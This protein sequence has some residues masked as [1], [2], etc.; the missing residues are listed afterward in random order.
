MIKAIVIDDEEKSRKV[1]IRLIEEVSE[2]INV[3]GEAGSVKEGFEVINKLKP[4][5]VFLDIEML[6]G[7]GFKLLEKFNKISFDVIFTTAYD[8]YAIR[9]FKFSALDYLLKPINVDDLESA[10]SRVKKNETS[11]NDKFALIE[12]LLQNVTMLSK[13]KRI[14]IKGATTIDYLNINEIMYCTSDLYLTEFFLANGNKISSVK[15]LKEY[16][17]LLDEDVFFRVSRSY[18]VNSNFVV[19]Y[20]K[21]TSIL[22]MSNNVEIELTRRRKKEFMD[23][24][25]TRLINYL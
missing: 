3:I 9:A 4:D 18:I 8:Q 15:P 5:L 24:M 23:Y 2:D 10:L 16:E 19:S 12:N 7:T 6:D 1:L 13:P 20:K 11:E 14:A 17:D 22:K 25:D 21:D